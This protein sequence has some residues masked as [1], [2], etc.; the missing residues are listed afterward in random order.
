MSDSEKIPIDCRS[1][2][3]FRASACMLLGESFFREAI[4]A[5]YGVKS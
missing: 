4:N 1:S 5:D 3:G 2:F